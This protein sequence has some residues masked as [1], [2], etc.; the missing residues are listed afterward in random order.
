MGWLTHVRR[1]LVYK[2]AGISVAAVSV[3]ILY[4]GY[5]TTQ[6]EAWLNKARFGKG[7]ERIVQVAALSVD[8]DDVRC[9]QAGCP[10]APAAR[11]R[12]R[13]FLDRVHRT[14]GLADNPLEL[15]GLPEPGAPASAL[16]IL[17]SHDPAREGSEHRLRSEVRAAY[18]RVTRKQKDSA[19][20]S[21]FGEGLGLSV[22]AFGAIRD[23]DGTRRALLS[24]EYRYGE[25]MESRRNIRDGVVVRSLVG[26][27][28]A[29]A[30]SALLAAGIGRRLRDLREAANAIEEERFEH[31]VA[32][33]GDDELGMVARQ[34]NR[35]AEHLA[36]KAWLLKFLPTYTHEAIMRRTRGDVALE[37]EAVHGTVMFTDIR[38]YTALSEGMEP[39]RV[40][41][42]LNLYLRRQAEILATHGGVIDKFIG[43]AVLALF[44]GD[45][46]EARAVA[47]AREIQVAIV[48]MNAEGVFD[49]PVS[50]GLGLASGELVLG[51]IGSDARR[52]R[53][54][55]GSVVNLASRLCS[56]AGENELFV[57]EGVRAAMGAALEIQATAEVELKGF[58]TLQRCHRVRDDE[59][60]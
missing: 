7:L 47:A 40:V 29:I 12:L 58:S 9:V 42:M 45:G 54:L 28:L 37:A 10:D 34:F 24:A 13:G 18:G 43:D 3:T 27:L 57:S 17:V 56:H 8:P 6:R 14:G 59:L 53:T 33:G 22:A 23:A 35:M 4:W 5:E 30:L 36:E 16:R 39:G 26:M 51:E 44:T 48:A 25:I 20:S 2:I 11:A 60:A 49:V 50:I 32:E 55:V 19:Y 46:H 21:P 41:A 52:E 38:G 1:R 15:L 31:R